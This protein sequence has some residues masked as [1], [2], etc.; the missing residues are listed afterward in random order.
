MYGKLFASLYQGTMRGKP[1]ELLVWTN[2]IAH[3]DAD[4]CVDIHPRA[5]ADEIGLTVEQ[6][7]AALL[8]LESPD[9]ES[10]T[11]DEEGRRLRRLDDHRAWGWKL[12]N[13]EKYNALRNEAERR[14]QNRLAQQK[15]RGKIGADSQQPSASVS[16]GQQ[17]SAVSANTDTDTD[18]DTDRSKKGSKLPRKPF[19]AP[20]LD[21]FTEFCGGLVPPLPALETQKAWLH[22]TEANWCRRGGLHVKDWKLTMR[23]WHV[24]WQQGSYAPPQPFARNGLPQNE[25]ARLMAEKAKIGGPVTG[26][27]PETAKRKA[28]HEAIDKQISQLP[29][30]P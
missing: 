20:S 10:R 8:T 25:Y 21:E 23:K 27:D 16:N 14:E 3:A 12:V 1:H 30:L 4:H 26:D 11:P 2:L 5:I 17:P 22:W 18:T 9:P 7:N 29:R 15:R 6:V 28:A 19:I 24:N 13:G